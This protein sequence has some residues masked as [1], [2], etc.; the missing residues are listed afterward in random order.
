MVKD[1]QGRKQYLQSSSSKYLFL[2]RMSSTLYFVFENQVNHNPIAE[3]SSQIWR[4]TKS[5]QAVKSGIILSLC[6]LLQRENLA[7]A[8]VSIEKNILTLN[9]EYESVE[10]R[11]INSWYNTPESNIK[12]IKMSYQPI[13]N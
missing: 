11:I 9:S 1:E 8:I 5:N 4:I 12:I 13:T 6:K 3:A 10:F 7:V 2:N